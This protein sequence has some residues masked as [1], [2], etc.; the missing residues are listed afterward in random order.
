MTITHER[1]IVNRSQESDNA[2]ASAM[3]SSRPGQFSCGP[4][5][6]EMV[7]RLRKLLEAMRAEVR[8]VSEACW[9]ESLAEAL[10]ARGCGSLLYAPETPVG[11]AVAAAWAAGGDGLPELVPYAAPVEELKDRIFTVD[12]AV[13]GS[14]RFSTKTSRCSLRSTLVMRSSSMIL[15][16]SMI[17]TWRHRCSASSR[18]GALKIER[19]SAATAL[20]IAID[21]T[22]WPAFCCRWK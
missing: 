13:T 17:A 18:S 21:G 19:M 9:V 20:R 15:P 1:R 12:A 16:W 14:R 7:E 11:R 22:Y 3:I 6:R 8:M 4:E 5:K 2:L 10:R